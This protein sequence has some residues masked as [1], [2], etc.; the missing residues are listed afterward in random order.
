M[1]QATGTL[2][3][4]RAL[5]NGGGAV[6]QASGSGR[7]P[8]ADHTSRATSWASP[9]GAIAISG[10][11]YGYV[12]TGTFHCC[13]METV[14]AAAVMT[15]LVGAAYALPG[16]APTVLV[17]LSVVFYL[18]LRLARAVAEAATTSVLRQR[19]ARGWRPVRV[20]HVIDSFSYGGAE[21]L[22]ATLNG[23]ASEA[24]LELS[25]ASLAPATPD[26]TQSLSLLVKAGLRP[27]F[28]GV[29]R[30]LD[31]KALRLLQRVIT[32]SGCQVVHAH[33]GYSAALVPLA[34][35]RLGIPCVST[36][37]HVPSP[38]RPRRELLKEQLWTRSAERGAALIYVSEAARRSAAALVGP[39]KP[40]WRVLHNGVDL[41]AYSPAASAHSTRL[42]ADLPVPP[43]S[44]VVTVVAALRAPKGHE[45]ALRAWPRVRARVPGAVLLVV[46]EGPHGPV[47]RAMAGEGVIFTGTREDVPTILRA[48]TLALLPSLTEALPT[49]MIEAAACGLAA[50]ATTVGGT[51]EVVDHGRTGLLVPPGN[52]DALVDAVT[53]LLADPDRRS[54]W[55]VAARNLA[56]ERFDL[57]RWAQRL[58]RL[59]EQAG[60]GPTW[61]RSRI[62]R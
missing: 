11:R 24:G 3:V 42:P 61:T 15:I 62:R 48:S 41:S 10:R 53:A 26:R 56:E 5:R 52:T 7:R 33:L 36:L 59:Y 37:H 6:V 38:D 57:R 46:G 34:A 60:V 43:G 21:R 29:R 49:V 19:P 25:V 22:L 17:R 23:V 51:P 35:R 1:E 54:R 44:P 32:A 20:L 2:Q 55:G 14:T 50:V 4:G 31:P 16:W 30:L 13:A 28:V 47:L 40:S 18:G 8:G 12:P 39:P 58:S 9:A 27:S 45:V